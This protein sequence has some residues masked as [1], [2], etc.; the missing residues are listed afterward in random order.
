MRNILGPDGL[1][2][3]GETEEDDDNHNFKMSLSFQRQE[4]NLNPLSVGMGNSILQMNGDI[5]E[6]CKNAI[7][8][9]DPSL[10]DT[11]TQSQIGNIN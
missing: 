3:E 7:K 6:R 9:A 5:T 11:N 10:P 1:P 4:C 8:Q 2:I